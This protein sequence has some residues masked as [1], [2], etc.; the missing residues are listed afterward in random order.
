MARL[1]PDDRLVRAP[2]QVLA[3][4]REDLDRD[5]LRDQVVLDDVSH[6]VEVRLGRRGEPDLD[7]LEAHLDELGE[8]DILA[9]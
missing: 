5:V 2:D 3:A 7:L 6:E 1:R 9:L 4:L 8:H